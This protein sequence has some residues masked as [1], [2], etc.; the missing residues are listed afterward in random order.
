M[1][2]VPGH[3][4]GLAEERV[5]VL[6]LQWRSREISRL[7]AGPWRRLAEADVA[8]A[9]DGVVERV[10][11][12]TFA[13]EQH[14]R[15]ALNVEL[16]WALLKI[17]E[18]RREIPTDG[19]LATHA[20]HR[21][22]ALTEA[23]EEKADARIC[24][25]FLSELSDLEAQVYRLTHAESLSRRQTAAALGVPAP[26]VKRVLESV[27]WRA[28]SFAAAALATRLCW[29][30]ALDLQA[31]TE[32]CATPEQMR[33]ARSHLRHCHQCRVMYRAAHGR[34]RQRA[35]SAISPAPVLMLEGEHHRALL[36]RVFEAATGRSS[37]RVTHVMAQPSTAGAVR[38]GGVLGGLGV[39]KVA[40][41][42]TAVVAVSATAVGLD[43]S[44]RRAP[45]HAL[46][47]IS[48][49]QTQRASSNAAGAGSPNRLFVP[50][51]PD[52]VYTPQR[53]RRS[54]GASTHR[55]APAGTNSTTANRPAT[56]GTS[57]DFFV[58][59]TPHS[60]TTSS[61]LARKATPAATSTST[62]SASNRSPDFFTP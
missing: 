5:A 40:A 23:A 7:R 6:V 31:H 33:R 41:G 17:K 26:E 52:R 61:S 51:I 37:A 56:R 49:S 47:G 34:F 16:R 39:A 60:T 4:M 35:V 21:S 44:P 55:S 25:E 18:R 1:S 54:R 45:S 38:A 13:N 19:F 28:K 20:D 12:Q 10:I 22:D 32:D 58:P 62:K 30:R 43:A 42:I 27:E 46:R 57:P 2:V 9:Y 14:L 59:S 29:R 11:Q 8:E 48:R 50:Q 24:E 3:R 15:A 36:H 53:T